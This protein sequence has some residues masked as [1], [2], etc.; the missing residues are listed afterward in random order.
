MKIYPTG[1]ANNGSTGPQRFTAWEQADESKA[2]LLRFNEVA[3]KR[4]ELQVM[5]ACGTL[6]SNTQ[7]QNN[8]WYL[9]SVVWDGTNLSF[10][11]NGVLDN[12]MAGK[13]PGG[14][15]FQRYEMGMSW[16]GYNTSQFFAHRFCEFRVWSRALSAS[17]IQGGICGVAANSEGLEA[18][19]KFNEGSGSTF[20]DATG[21]GFDMDWTKSQRAIYEGDMLPTPDAANAIQWAKDDINKCA[22]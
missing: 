19:W 1:L 4:G 7:F 22:N 20:K 15:N 18:Y 6:V 13:D 21:H 2:M 12:Q 5:T 14:I 10:Y 8:Q 17:E 16:G 11:V 3:P 9:L